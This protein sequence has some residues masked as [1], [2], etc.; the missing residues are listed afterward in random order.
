LFVHGLVQK[1]PK[2]SAF[3][4]LDLETFI[5]Q[6]D[7][8]KLLVLASVTSD[9]YKSEDKIWD[10]SVYPYRFG[11]QEIYRV[12]NM[13]I[14]DKFT[15]KQMDALRRSAI[16]NGKIYILPDDT[17]WLFKG[18]RDKSISTTPHKI[19]KKTVD[20]EP[21]LQPDYTL[22]DFVYETGYK[23]EDIMN[24]VKF[25]TRKQHVIF[26]GPPGTGKTYVAER[27]ARYLVSKSTDQWEVV[28]FHPAY[29][30]EDFIQG[31][32][33]VPAGIAL[34]FELKSGRFLEF[35]DRAAKDKSDSPYVLIIDE[36]NRANLARVF[37]ELMYLMEYRDKA[38]ALAAGGCHFKI[39]KNV[40]LIGTM[41]TADRSIALVDHALR[42]RFSFIRLK[43]EYKIL[44]GELSKYNFPAADLIL[45]LKEINQAIDDPNYEVGIS[46]FMVDGKH[47]K[48]LLPCIWIS[49][50]EPYLEEYFYDQPGKVKA[51]RWDTLIQNKLKPWVE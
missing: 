46:F 32:Y 25:V 47:L 11:L 48:E 9:I 36:I 44:E 28:Q 2:S 37:G 43:P 3:P 45:T 34:Q 12:E 49:E 51:Y 16:N 4:R 42:R 40:F 39:P 1:N 15:E 17:S 7:Q 6:V 41:N 35:C 31:Y 26:Q 20:V 24:W 38:I 21:I 18:I 5:R 50:I 14:A 27:L 13:P 22:D 10:D 23:V 30:Y 8:S 33:P 29:S 19:P